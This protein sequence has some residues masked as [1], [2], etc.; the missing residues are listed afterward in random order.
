M[1]SPDY[2]TASAY[3]LLAHAI[4]HVSMIFLLYQADEP[5]HAGYSGF[6]HLKDLQT[7]GMKSRKKAK[8]SVGGKAKK[9]TW[10]HAEPEDY[11][12]YTD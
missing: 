11:K 12:R 3:H 2:N 10:Q 8:T 7:S 5:S 4:M 1:C 6:T 9:Q